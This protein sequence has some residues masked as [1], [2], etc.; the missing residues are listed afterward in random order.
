MD[1]GCF[2]MSLAVKDIGASKDFYQ[3]IGFTVIDG[4]ID[5]KWLI[6]QNGDA[7]VGLFEGMFETNM[8]NFSPKDVRSVQKVLKAN[9]YALESEANGEE[10][11]A[12]ISAKDPDGNML[13]FDQY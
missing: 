7:K 5:Q 2:S 3:T 9:G 1:L 8:I 10:G 12:H 6:L 13:F 4:N 11:A